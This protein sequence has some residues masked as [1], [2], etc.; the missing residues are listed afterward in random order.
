MN[1]QLE[2]KFAL[3]TGSSAGIGFAIAKALAA[4]GARVIVNGR[5]EARVTEAIAAIRGHI[6]SARLDGLAL[7][8]SKA[9]AAMQ[10]LRTSFVCGEDPAPQVSANFFALWGVKPILAADDFDKVPAA[11]LASMASWT[12]TLAKTSSCRRNSAIVF[13]LTPQLEYPFVALKLSMLINR[14]VSFTGK[15]FRSNS[16]KA[17]FFADT[18]RPC[19]LCFRVETMPHFREQRA[20]RRGLEAEI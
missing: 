1:L 14:S 12:A 3:V 6:P 16:V 13:K 19:S 15:G 5:S 20:K 17:D 4:E 8:S 7:D 9:D 18:A 2:N 11:I 10:R